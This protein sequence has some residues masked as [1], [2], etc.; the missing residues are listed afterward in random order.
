LELLTK[1]RATG[2]PVA[3]MQRYAELVRSGSGEADRLVLLEEHRE[4]VNKLQAEL[5]ACAELLDY[6]ID[7]YRRAA[8]EECMR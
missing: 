1:L 2:M 4:R 6:K 8:A 7:F 3:Q 5:D